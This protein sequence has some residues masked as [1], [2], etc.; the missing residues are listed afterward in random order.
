MKIK[1]AL[2]SAC[3]IISSPV[4]A[5]PEGQEVENIS[6]DSLSEENQSTEDESDRS[7]SPADQGLEDAEEVEKSDNEESK[8]SL[9]YYQQAK[10]YCKENPRKCVLYAV[11]T[12]AAAIGIG[13]AVHQINE[14][15]VLNNMKQDM[16]EIKGDP[17]KRNQ[18]LEKHFGSSFE[19]YRLTRI[20]AQQNLWERAY[21]EDNIGLQD[22]LKSNDQTRISPAI[23][24][25]MIRM[26]YRSRT[27][28]RLI[29]IENQL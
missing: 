28:L 26:G 15:R 8:P 5:G 3:L 4:F 10:A 17:Y 23:H 13:Y 24:Q 7:K 21:S 9:S 27:M 2:L 22:L 6:L 20:D 14:S 1:T 16:A 12:V 25:E 18:F 19:L 29:K 11:G